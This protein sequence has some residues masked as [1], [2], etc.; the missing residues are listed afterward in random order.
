MKNYLRR[1]SVYRKLAFMKKFLLNNGYIP[2]AKKPKTYNEKILHRKINSNVEL[3]ADYADKIKVKEIVGDVVGNEYIIPTYYECESITK[4]IVINLL[5]VHEGLVLKANHNSGNV[6]IIDRSISSDKLS[7][8]VDEL[9]NQ[10]KVNYGNL[11]DERW[12]SLI[13]PKILIEKRLYDEYGRGD[14]KDYK[15]HAFKQP[16]GEC[17]IILHVDFDRNKNHT[18]SFFDEQLNWLP[19][20]LGYPSIYTTIERPKNYEVML[21]IVKELAKPFSYVR[22]DLYNINGSIYF[23]EMT[24]A[25]GSG[26]ESFSNYKYDAWLGHFWKLDDNSNLY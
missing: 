7:Y 26:S 4:D 15:F 8:I 5:E 13:K 6:Y 2:N 10:L 1:I 18:R 23:G 19:F 20:S 12:Y 22:I 17:E 21:S 9:N 11:K 3:F 14:I 25:H 16:N 24:F